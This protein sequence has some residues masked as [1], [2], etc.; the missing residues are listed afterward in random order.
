V[1]MPVK[2]C[3]KKLDNSDSQLPN[4]TSHFKV[5]YGSDIVQL[6]GVLTYK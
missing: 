3:S 1:R 6:Q 4:D 5:P 2:V